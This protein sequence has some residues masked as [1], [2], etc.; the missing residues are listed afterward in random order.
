MKVRII[1]FKA[2]EKGIEYLGYGQ[3]NIETEVKV[4]DMLDA[5]EQDGD[6]V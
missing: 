3:K 2:G 4:N 6:I 5:P 1:S